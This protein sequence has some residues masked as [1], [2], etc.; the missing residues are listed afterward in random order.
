MKHRK[1]FFYYKKGM[2]KYFSQKKAAK[3]MSHKVIG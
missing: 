1:I 3:R 2:L